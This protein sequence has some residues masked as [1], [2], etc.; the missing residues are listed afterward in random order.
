MFYGL[1]VDSHDA[2]ELHFIN[3]GIRNSTII[4]VWPI[5]FIQKNAQMIPWKG[6]TK[7]K[8]GNKRLSEPLNI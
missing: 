6:K 8:V 3:Q 1:P 7:E 5:S 2:R 4:K